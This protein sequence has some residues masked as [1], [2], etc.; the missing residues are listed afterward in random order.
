MFKF[1]NPF[2]P[3]KR[4]FHFIADNIYEK[5]NLLFLAIIKNCRNNKSS[6]HQCLYVH[7]RSNHVFSEEAFLM[8]VEIWKL[9]ERK[10]KI[11]ILHRCWLLFL[12]RFESFPLQWQ[13]ILE[14]LFWGKTQSDSDNSKRKRYKWISSNQEKIRKSFHKKK[15]SLLA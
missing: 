7:K 9:P 4:V 1:A 10:N 3:F 13:I 8:R 12:V 11:K 15:G 5:Q 6:N 2:S 14:N